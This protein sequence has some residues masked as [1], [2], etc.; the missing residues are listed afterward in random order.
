MSK[1]VFAPVSRGPSGL[2]S[3]PETPGNFNFKILTFKKKPVHEKKRGT[4]K[5]E[6]EIFWRDHVGLVEICLRVYSDVVDD[7]RVYEKSLLT[8]I[9]FES[10]ATLLSKSK[11]EWIFGDTDPP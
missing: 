10:P 6:S 4:P 5:V 3:D 8:E 9:F 11:S 7:N 1:K 2:P